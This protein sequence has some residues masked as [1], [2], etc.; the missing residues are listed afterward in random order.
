MN[1]KKTLLLASVVFLFPSFS[2]AQMHSTSVASTASMPSD[3]GGQM[4]VQYGASATSLT[5]APSHSLSDWRNWSSDG[6]ASGWVAPSLWVSSSAGG[7]FPSHLV[8]MAGGRPQEV[9][10][11]AA[12]VVEHTAERVQTTPRLGEN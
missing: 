12:R 11:P 10:M 2:V 6:S 5:A 9:V 3:P 8:R 7:G 4:G 1:A